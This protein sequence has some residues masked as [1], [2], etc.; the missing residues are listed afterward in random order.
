MA[1][2]TKES[3]INIRLV[4]GDKAVLERAA[5]LKR[6]SLSSY[7]LS[8]AMEAARL[9]IQREETIHLSDAA[10]DKLLDLLENPPEPTEAL[11]KLFH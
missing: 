9:D 11:R 8:A 10:R 5:S 3:R 7:I 6:V 4:P 1:N 2:Q